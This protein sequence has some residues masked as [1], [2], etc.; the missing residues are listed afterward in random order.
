MR[1][2]LLSEAAHLAENDVRLSVIGRRDR[3]PR[4][5][6]GAI[7]SA[8][9]ATLRGERLHLRIAVDYSAREAILQ[10][11]ALC[12]SG[13][14][15]TREEFSW[16]LTGEASQRGRDVDL[17]IRSGGE[18]RLS[19]FLLWESAYAELCFTDRMWPDFRSEDLS[20]AVADFRR[21]ERRFGA[22][23]QASAP[24]AAVPSVPSA[25]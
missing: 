8:E 18:R 5:L 12:P 17:L 15:P 22:L 10:A 6:A 13:S 19:D 2:Y 20:A 1:R 7:A 9:Q 14:G 24:A 4:A 16:L 21:R 25:A 11:A 23:G 3:L